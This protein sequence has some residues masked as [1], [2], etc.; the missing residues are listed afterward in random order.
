MDVHNTH[1]T[2]LYTVQCITVDRYMCITGMTGQ[3]G[4]IGAKE[5][6]E[7]QRTTGSCDS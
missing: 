2:L 4:R 7:R 6:E 1:I 3:E 5:E